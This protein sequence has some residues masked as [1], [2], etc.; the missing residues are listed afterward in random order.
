MN[1]RYSNYQ[2]HAKIDD[3]GRLINLDKYINGEKNSLQ[4]IKSY[5]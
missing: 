4:E 3:M 2:L 5:Y 1:R